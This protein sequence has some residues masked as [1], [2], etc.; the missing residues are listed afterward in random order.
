MVKSP[1]TQAPATQKT[2]T[3][4]QENK[5]APTSTDR[6]RENKAENQPKGSPNSERFETESAT[7]N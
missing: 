4:A 1:G 6:T 5:P 2:N 7:D 3:T